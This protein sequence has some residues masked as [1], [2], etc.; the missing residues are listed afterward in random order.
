MNELD[1]M[2]GDFYHEFFDPGDLVYDIGAHVGKWTQACLE[3]GAGHVVAIEPQHALAEALV[4]RFAGKP[5]SVLASAVGDTPGTANMFQCEVDTIA[6]LDPT[7]TQQRFAGYAWKV[8]ETVF[9][10]TLDAIIGVY[11]LPRFIKIDVEGFEVKVLEGL[12]VP[13]DSFAIE[14]T[15]EVSDHLIQCINLIE[16]FGIPY[17]YSYNIGD[18]PIFKCAWGDRNSVITEL[19]SQWRPDIWGNAYMRRRG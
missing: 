11:G 18:Y 7:W 2:N 19:Q 4:Q 16:Q 17:E 12:S 5:V 6:T 3:N 13:I 8:G 14:Y 9:V 10:N 15:A 1:R